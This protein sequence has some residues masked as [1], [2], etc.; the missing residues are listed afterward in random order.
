MTA[1]ILS[2]SSRDWIFALIWPVVIGLAAVDPPE[3]PRLDAEE[4]DEAGE[5]RCGPVLPGPDCHDS[6]DGL[7]VLVLPLT[8]AGQEEAEGDNSNN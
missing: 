7:V 8:L 6:V 4:A 5:V 1:S 3:V 2:I